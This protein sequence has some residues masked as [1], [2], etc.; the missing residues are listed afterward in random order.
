[1]HLYF[2]IHFRLQC[3][4]AKA[5]GRTLRIVATGRFVFATTRLGRGQLDILESTA[6]QLQPDKAHHGGDTSGETREY[7]CTDPTGLFE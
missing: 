6:R 7:L 2:V 4:S 1:M 5:G 3:V